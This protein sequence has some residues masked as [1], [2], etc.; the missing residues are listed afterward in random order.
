[1]PPD[2]LILAFDTS[3]A[4]CAAALVSGETVIAKHTEDMTRGQAEALLPILRNLLSST[5]HSLADIDG[6]G[7]GTGPGNFTG[8][9]IA[10]STAR[11][12]AM[13][14]RIPAV[15]VTGFQAL[16]VRHLDP[17]WATVPAPRDQVYVKREPGT[18]P[19]QLLTDDD[20]R[21]LMAAD[22][23][24]VVGALASSAQNRP[25]PVE[26]GLCAARS[27]ASGTFLAAPVP[28]YVRPADAAPPRE[29]PPVIFA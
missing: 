5:D 8:I 22:P 1:M 17:V 9:R 21:T 23:L 27:L 6:I 10:V 24:P 20:A 2:P 25:D 16:A 29:S 19:A 15:G 26:I 12:L 3:A 11:G 4:H 18:D 14:L 7:V 13:S 28:F